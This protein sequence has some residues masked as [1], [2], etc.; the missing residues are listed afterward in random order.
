MSDVS[1]DVDAQFG[2]IVSSFED[3]KTCDKAVKIQAVRSCCGMV[4]Q[5]CMDCYNAVCAFHASKDYNSTSTHNKHTF[6]GRP[7]SQVNFI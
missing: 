7:F 4:D 2:A 1:V 6:T 5:F 3:D